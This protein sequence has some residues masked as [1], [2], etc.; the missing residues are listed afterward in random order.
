MEIHTGATSHR[1]E[2]QVDNSFM[3]IHTGSTSHRVEEQVDNSFMEIHTGATS[4]RVEEQVDNSFM[5][6]H[7]G[8]TSYRVEE[9]VDNSFMEIHTG[10]TSHRVKMQVQYIGFIL[11]LLA[12]IHILGVLMVHSSIHCQCIWDE[13]G[14][15]IIYSVMFLTNARARGWSWRV[16]QHDC[17]LC[18]VNATRKLR[19]SAK[20]PLNLPKRGIVSQT[21]SDK[22]LLT[23]LCKYHI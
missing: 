4:H 14:V 12:R 3:E 1:V 19:E 7:T 20:S 23:G 22:N 9:Q 15:S 2:E 10:A 21:L 17:A 16:R 6:I 5:E 13:A 8:A 18:C 11:V